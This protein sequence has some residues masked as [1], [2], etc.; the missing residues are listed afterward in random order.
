M[1]KNWV[2]SGEA[3]SEVK[4]SLKILAKIPKL[5]CNKSGP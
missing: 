1:G 3:K 5:Y 4:G 2:M